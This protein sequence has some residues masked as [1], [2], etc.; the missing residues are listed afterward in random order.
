MNSYSKDMKYI[1]SQLVKTLPFHNRGFLVEIY[2]MVVQNYF[3][4]HTYNRGDIAEIW[5]INYDDVVI[6]LP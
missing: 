4:H 1:L 3:F 6:S 5:T 2:S